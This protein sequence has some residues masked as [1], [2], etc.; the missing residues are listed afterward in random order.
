MHI[1]QLLPFRGAYRR[2]PPI[3]DAKY[4]LLSMKDF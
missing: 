4:T 3:T 2:I 1:Y